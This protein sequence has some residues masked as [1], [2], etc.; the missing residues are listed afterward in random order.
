MK[1]PINKTKTSEVAALYSTNEFNYTAEDE[2]KWEGLFLN[3][4]KNQNLF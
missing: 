2:K 1:T 4:N 3:F